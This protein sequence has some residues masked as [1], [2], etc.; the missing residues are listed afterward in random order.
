MTFIIQTKDTGEFRFTVAVRN[1]CFRA[2]AL[3]Y[4]CSGG[5]SHLQFAALL[6]TQTI[7]RSALVLAM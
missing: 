4:I 2:S 5:F 7:K 6:P 1:L 3:Q